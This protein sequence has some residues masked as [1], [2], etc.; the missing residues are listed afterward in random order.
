MALF[1]RIRP[2]HAISVDG[3]RDKFGN[4]AV[5]N[6]VRELRQIDPSQ[7]FLPGIVEQTHFH[8]RGIGREK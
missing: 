7:L 5:P 6:L 4:V 1:R 2:M 8:L 3:A